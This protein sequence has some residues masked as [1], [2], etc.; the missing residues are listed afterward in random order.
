M[1]DTHPVIKA[2]IAVVIHLVC[3]TTVLHEGLC[4]D[5]RR[6]ELVYGHLKDLGTTLFIAS[7]KLEKRTFCSM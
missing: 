7:S 1:Q 3:I 4:D 5:V 6:G 2:V